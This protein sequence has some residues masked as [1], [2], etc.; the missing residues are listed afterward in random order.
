MTDRRTRREFLGLTALAAVGSPRALRAAPAAFV[1]RSIDPDL[2]LFNAKVHTMDAALPT[3]EA[4]AVRGGRFVAV[5]RSADVR[6][7]AGPRTRAIDAKGMTVVPGFIDCHN[8]AGGT[9][10]LYEVLVGN[11]FEVEFV[12]IDSIVEKLRARARETPPG[13]WVAGYFHDDTKLKD[14][15]PLTVRDLDRVSTEHPVVVNHRGGHTS[16]YNTTAFELAHVGRD[17]PNPPGGTFDRDA[18]GALNGRVTDRARAVFANVGRRPT[19][20]PAEAARRERDGLAHISKQFAR[21]GLTSVHHEGGD[22]AALQD[23]RARGDLH[24]RVSYEASGRVLD[25]M[26]ASGILTG[27]GDE[28]IRF[29][30][31]SEHTVDGS[32]SERT[33]AMSVPYA[34]TT[35]KGN[36][37]ETQAE[38]DA[39]VERVHRA[40]IQVNCHANGDVAIDMYLTAFERA[41]RAFP[42]ADARPKITHCTLVNA[43]LVRRMKALG[44]VPAMFTTYAYYNT[45]KF[46]FYGAELMTRCMAFRT[47]LD[48]GIRAAAGSDFSPGPFAPLMGI[49]G[50]VMRTGWDGTTWGAN[51]RVTVDEAIRINTLHGAW[52]SKEEALKGSI[53]AGKLADF[54]VLA[55]DP[56]AVP[57][58]KI[59]D[60]AIVRTVVGGETTYEA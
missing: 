34:G 17:T 11:P 10:L 26:L 8:H 5:G 1:D 47:M 16:F 27:F 42:R 20:G 39:W 25:A 31:T 44:A 15:R 6:S 12:T 21:Y 4:F 13:T 37:T 23:V 14:G 18:S 41:Q 59:K 36:V 2:V 46:P 56:H 60:V 22:L 45:D 7:L 33:M 19:Y 35:Y 29:G 54:V 28:W 3:A 30:A 43:D 49:Q 57:A 48:A 53:A 40:G 50:M 55:D 58:E 52:A 32:F 51:Q 24:H 38:L 9:T